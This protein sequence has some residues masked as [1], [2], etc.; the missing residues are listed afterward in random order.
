MTMLRFS[1]A[2][3]AITKRDVQA[4]FI[5]IARSLPTQITQT[6]LSCY[7]VTWALQHPIDYE[8]M[9]H[10]KIYPNKHR[11]ESSEIV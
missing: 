5:A 10:W 11:E 4:Q 3:E 6:S 8:S 7:H 1:E 9:T 2:L